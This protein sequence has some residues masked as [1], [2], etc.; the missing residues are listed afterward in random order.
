MELETA[1]LRNGGQG[2]APSR[3]LFIELKTIGESNSNACRG[4]LG[5]FCQ[6]QLKLLPADHNGG[7]LNRLT[8]T[9][10]WRRRLRGN[11]WDDSG[12]GDGQFQALISSCQIQIEVL[13]SLAADAVS[14]LAKNE[15]C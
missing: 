8:N 4:K 13:F 12:T 10:K 14:H 7:R 15:W 11:F 1:N 3:A 9:R 5:G 2:R 6:K